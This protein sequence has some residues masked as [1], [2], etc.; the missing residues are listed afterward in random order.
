M[1]HHQLIKEMHKYEDQMTNAERICAYT[2]GK[3]VDRLPVSLSVRENMAPL[4]GY[5]QGDYRRSFAVKALVYQKAAADFDCHGISIGPNL[6]KIGEALGA[7]AHYPEHGPDYLSDF[8]LLDYDD[9]SGYSIPSPAKSLVL[10]TMIEEISAYKLRFGDD[11]PVSTEIAGPLSTAVSIRPMNDVLLDFSLQPQELMRLLDFSV[12]C[13]LAWVQE[14]QQKFGITSVNIAEPVASSSVISPQ[15]FRQFV[16]APLRRLVVEVETITN[17]KPGLH[18][19][20]RTEPVWRQLA[21]M[22]F[23]SFRVD[24]VESLSDLKNAMGGQLLL[25]GNVPPVEIMQQGSIDDVVAAGRCCIAQAADSPC[26]FILAAGCQLPPGV[27]A[28]NMRALLLAARK[29]G[30]HA[31]LGKI[32]P[33]A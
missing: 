17:K 15:T 27:S 26:G 3:E 7:A 25:A 21:E 19:C 14:V 11:F 1:D 32:C 10:Q 8:P 20:G 5:S 12:D 31:R 18:I 9:L 28:D 33:D 29:Y 22:G 24:S 13:Q 6:K 2:A 30:R 4:Y 23:S 16:A